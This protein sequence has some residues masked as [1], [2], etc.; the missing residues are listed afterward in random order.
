VN[1]VAAQRSAQP[2]YAVYLARVIKSQSVQ[3]HRAAVTGDDKLPPWVFFS[4]GCRPKL[5]GSF[6]WSLDAPEEDFRGA[7]SGAPFDLLLNSISPPMQLAWDAAVVA[8]K[9]FIKAIKNGELIANGAH[10]ATG[11]RHDLDPAEWTREGL[12]LN[13]H[14]GDLFEGCYI[15]QVRRSSDGDLFEGRNIKHLR[16]STITLRAAI[17]EQKLGRI[18]WDD[19][20]ERDVARREQ[21][22]L[23]NEKDYSRQTTPFIIERYGVS[24]VDGGDLRR[25]KLALY[26]GD[27]ERPKRTRSK[28]R[29]KRTRP[30]HK[31]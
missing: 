15:K 16:W 29:P 7:P 11:V 24:R 22:S 27:L 28:K 6:V 12:I 14:N 9:K 4:A 10:P 25:F 17:P 31:G 1:S 13:V 3:C 5:T 18:D 23:P 20:W 2:L 19:L 21:G 8:F 26:R 30:K